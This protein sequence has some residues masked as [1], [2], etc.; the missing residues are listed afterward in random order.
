MYREQHTEAAEY[1]GVT[2][3]HLL[4]VLAEFVKEGILEKTKTGYRIIDMEKLGD[5][6]V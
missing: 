6:C 5:I 1:L 3:R 4:Y 2:Y